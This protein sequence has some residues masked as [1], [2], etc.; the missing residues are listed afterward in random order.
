MKRLVL[1]AAAISMLAVP[2]AFAAD[3]WNFRHNDR[4]RHVS[5]SHDGRHDNVR[6]HVDRKPRWKRGQHLSN[7]QRQRVVRD[8]RHYGLRAPGR[9]QEWVRVGNDYILVSILSGVIAG[10]VAGH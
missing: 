5:R 10:M 1:A 6:K 4:D 2:S 3:G 9:G 8:H 7:W